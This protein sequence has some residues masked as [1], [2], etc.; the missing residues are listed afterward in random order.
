M[1]STCPHSLVVP[2][3]STPERALSAW[4]LSQRYKHLFKTQKE[5]LKKGKER[6][7][8]VNEHAFDESKLLQ[9]NIYII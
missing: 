7:D 3:P 8:K 9:K 2:A 6:K 4:N 1:D 5:R